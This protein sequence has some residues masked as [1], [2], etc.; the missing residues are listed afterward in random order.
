M[1]A[2]GTYQYDLVLP[3]APPPARPAAASAAAAPGRSCLLAQRHHDQ[4]DAQDAVSGAAPHQLLFA[5]TNPAR[6]NPAKGDSTCSARMDDSR[7]VSSDV[8]KVALASRP[9]AVPCCPRRPRRIAAAV[10]V[11]GVGGVTAAASCHRC[12]AVDLAV[13]S[14]GPPSP[15]VRRVAVY[16]GRSRRSWCLSG[17]R[18]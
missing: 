12:A 9:A 3:G 10:R 15:P 8:L 16:R 2:R 4:A 5:R 18:D 17:T 11:C 1:S 13:G 6:T 14:G 7:V